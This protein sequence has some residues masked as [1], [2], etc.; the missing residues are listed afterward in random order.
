MA[1]W[2]DSSLGFAPQTAFG[3]ENATPGD[4][5]YLKCESPSIT[6]DTEVTELDLLTGQVGAAPE[7]IVGRRSGSVSFT[8]PAE[9]LKS[10]YDPTA[11]DPG[12]AG[13]I[14][15]ILAL[16]GNA[17]GSY[18]DNWVGGVNTAAEF[19]SGVQHLSCSDYNSNGVT[20]ATSTI[21]TMQPAAAGTTLV[22]QYVLTGESD[23]TSTVQTGFA[24]TKSGN[25]VTVFEAS[26]HT[27]NSPTADVFGTVT[28]WQSGN[29]PIPLTIRFVG[30]G[31]EL[32]YRLVDAICESFTLNLNAAET[33][34]VEM[35]FR[36]YNFIADKTIGGL[37]VPDAFQRV[38]TILGTANGRVTVG[39]L[40]TCGLED[41]TVS[42]SAGDL[43]TIVC[44]SED[45]GIESVQIVRP[46]VTAAFSIPHK[47]TDPIFDGGGSSANSGAHV[48]QSA[49]ELGTR[50]S[51]GVEVGS[52]VGRMLSI[53]I[54]SG[55][56]TQAPVDVGELVR[57]SVQIEASTYSAD[58][59]DTAE[60]SANSPLDSIFRIAQ[61]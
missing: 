10:G 61:G 47:T 23:T 8:I 45:S 40:V 53:L 33:P 60:T 11:E 27:V 32:G 38:P 31:T 26:T 46:V 39:S 54:P 7:R 37:V 59:T 42:W 28:A 4:F 17:V 35:S 58:S 6:F 9:G 5:K 48:W 22:G 24:K 14:P 13:V 57:Y 25:D 51:F 56:V 15:Y 21:I 2:S 12:D 19:F 44:H 41:V 36:F 30:N 1:Y 34:T 55:I 52:R 50:Y 43:R 18:A 16:I 3:T 29:Q 49:L 20:S